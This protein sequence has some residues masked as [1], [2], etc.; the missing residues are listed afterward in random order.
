VFEDDHQIKKFME[1]IYEFANTYIDSDEE[2]DSKQMNEEEIE[3]T[4]EFND[5]MSE[6]KVL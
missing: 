6:H 4:P 3:I 2:E 5:Y 1:V